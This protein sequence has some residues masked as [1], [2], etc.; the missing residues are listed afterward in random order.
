[1]L[2][3]KIEDDKNGIAWTGVNFKEVSLS[4]DFIGKYILL[5]FYNNSFT[6]DY[7]SFIKQIEELSEKITKLS[8]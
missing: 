5:I 6:K 8:K 4:N 1:M 7:K 3:I 2:G